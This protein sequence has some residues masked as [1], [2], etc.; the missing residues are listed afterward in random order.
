MTV[1]PLTARDLLCPRWQRVAALE[2]Y[3][4]VASDPAREAPVYAVFDETG[5]YLGL[6]EARQA[7]IFPGR[8]F[9]DL[10]VR[11]QP[12]PVADDTAI[13]TVLGLLD[14][15]GSDHLAVIAPGGDFI[16]VISRLSIISGVCARE[17]ALRAERER[18]IERL[19]CELE[20]REVAA[21][22][23]DG[24]LEGIMVTD[25]EQRILLV[26]RAFS[27]TTGYSA[28]EAIGQTPRLLHSGRH[29]EAFYRAMWQSLH[30]VGLWEGEIWNRRKDG[31]IYPEWLRIQTVLDAAGQ[32]RYYVGI[33]SD[34][35][36]HQE[37]RAKLL[38]LA[39][40]DTLTGLP[41]RQLLNDRLQ[42]AIAHGSRAQEGFA[43][44]YLDLDRF[45]DLNDTRGHRFG[46]QV[47]IAVAQRLVG[48]L[49]VSDTVARLGGDEFV[50]LLNDV[51]Q[52]GAIVE[53]AQKVL[54]LLAQPIDIGGERVYTGA[55]LGIARF[56]EDGADADT[57]IMKADA[58]LYRA[59]DEGR[60]RFHFH[61]DQ[62]HDRLRLR[63]ERVQALRQALEH[64]GLWLAWQPQVELAS[65]GIVGAEA[66][67]R[68]TG[69][70]GS[71]VPPAEFVGLAE[72]AGLIEA[73]GDW[74]L[75]Q[76]IREAPH[77]LAASGGRLRLGVNLSPLQ[78]KPGCAERLL[79]LLALHG[80]AARHL[81]VELTESALSTQREG[82]LPLLTALVADGAG[83][84]VDDFG[85]GC[86]NLAMLKALPI[87]Q[88]KID[89]SFIMDLEHDGNDRQIVA[90][91]IDMAHALGLEV[92]AEGV[93]TPAQGDILRERGCDL[94][95][96]YLFAQPLAL[97]QLLERLR[98]QA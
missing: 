49:R 33:F 61:S 40:Y 15:T 81:M 93:E 17:Q 67:L 60:G 69:G 12:P 43:L 2:R 41:N 83:I 19:T 47:L 57:L 87:T 70:D 74:V 51:R 34:I 76:L 82:V 56:P 37:M 31:E 35:S 92:V 29:D 32:R 68:W 94:A 11:R 42:Q 58:A 71:P 65:G 88:L 75:M 44:L 22:V 38:H 26:N 73:L 79:R 8:V 54:E 7:A 14:R 1:P 84:A 16:G 46:D 55:S 36:Q 5:G 86:S 89:R 3:R 85:T 62:L 96:G 98:S 72:E 18:L 13:D 52:E 20:H 25:A 66:L 77:I 91:M 53:T 78:L 39:Y 28:E 24:M 64:G 48:S 4:D 21:A 45:K 95:Q 10:L 59:K 80:L 23:F 27:E 97:P 30:Q 90:A 50:I 63:L 9:A 6:V